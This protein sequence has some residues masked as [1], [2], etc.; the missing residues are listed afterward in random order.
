MRDKQ[1]TAIILIF[2]LLVL[3]GCQSMPTYN[4]MDDD[5]AYSVGAVSYQINPT[6]SKNGLECL[7]IMPIAIGPD[8]HDP[9]TF[10]LSESSAADSLNSIQKDEIY[11]YR[12]E[13]KDKEKMFRQALYGFI[14]PHKTRDIEL[15]KVD[16]WAHAGD[17]NPDYLKLSK[18]L[19]CPWFLEGEIT[20]FSAD[21][22]GVYSNITVAA[23]LQIIRA[24]D[25]KVVWQGK[26][27]ARSDD[28][29]LPF[30]PI[31]LA[32]GAVKAASNINPEQVEKTTGD[33][34][35]RLVRTMPL[36]AN[37]NFL[38]AAKR[39]Q[40]LRVIAKALNLRKGPGQ[41]YEVSKVLK[42]EEPLTLIDS[43]EDKPWL[44]VRTEDGTQGYVAG[45]YV[46]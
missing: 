42:H 4:S 30:S 5:K 10:N 39:K 37:N 8:V 24:K 11:D 35:R 23:E 15:S 20:A 44:L 2:V 12:L 25:Q 17:L 1:I 6:L 7:V 22:Y 19:N 28:G 43:V 29:S 26:H 34:A 40:L 32:V 27:E 13:A 46:N 31:D 41:S 3:S 45:R 33:L 9:V 36:D 38:F 21:F 14:A 18:K 16:R